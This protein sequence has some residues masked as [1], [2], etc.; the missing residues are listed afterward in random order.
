MRA[1]VWLN[2]HGLRLP[3]PDPTGEVPHGVSYAREALER[4]GPFPENW[5]VGEDTLVNRRMLEAGVEIA[6]APEVVTRHRYPTSLGAAL[7]DSYRRGLRRGG[8]IRRPAVRRRLWW[9]SRGPA[10]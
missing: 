4:H 3:L 10:R 7:A 2:E 6:W 5:L 8:A 1:R 9:I